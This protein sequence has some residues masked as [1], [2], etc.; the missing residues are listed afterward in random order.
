MKKYAHI[1]TTMIPKTNYQEVEG[2]IVNNQ[3][4]YYSF[5][6]YYCVIYF[7]STILTQQLK[8]S[9]NY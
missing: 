3:Q 1:V 5:I 6:I 2:K 9:A 7:L 4:S 8:Y